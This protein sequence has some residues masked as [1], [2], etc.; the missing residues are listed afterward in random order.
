[1]FFFEIIFWFKFRIFIVYYFCKLLNNSKDLLSVKMS[2][3]PD[4]E[5]LN[6]IKCH[7]INQNMWFE[8]P[9]TRGDE[10]LTY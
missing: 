7:V 10:G 6:M 3:N 9:L 1:M 5:S 2:A 8:Y 4:D